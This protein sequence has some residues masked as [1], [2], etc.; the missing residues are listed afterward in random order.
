[1]SNAYQDAATRASKNY[2]DTFQ[3]TQ[4]NIINLNA[5]NINAYLKSNDRIDF[6][7]IKLLAV[8]SKF[9][10]MFGNELVFKD[11]TDLSF[12]IDKIKDYSADAPYDIGEEIDSTDVQK[13]FNL[14]VDRTYTAEYQ[15]SDI[16]SIDY[17]QIAESTEFDPT[18]S[19]YTDVD[20]ATGYTSPI[21]G[22]VS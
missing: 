7:Q 15:S 21:I 10:T 11:S 20:F 16:P 17:A 4:N 19:I 1:M 12:L 6:E 13:M 5:R 22:G 14:R 3:S 18:L 8:L 2:F 9:Q